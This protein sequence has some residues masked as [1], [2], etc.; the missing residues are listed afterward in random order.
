MKLF[1]LAIM[2]LVLIVTDSRVL[3]AQ[4]SIAQNSKMPKRLSDTSHINST[5][6]NSDS[7]RLSEIKQ[8]YALAKQYKDG[9]DVP[10]DYAKAFYYF[11][12]AAALGD[13]QSKYAEGYFYFKGLFVA[14]DYGIAAGLFQEGAYLGRDNSMYMLGLCFRNGYGLPQNE[15]SAQYWLKKSADAGYR[16]AILELQSKVPENGDAQAKQLVQRIHNAA[17]PEQVALNQF[18]ALQP[19]KPDSSI[20]AG[21]YEG[22]VIQYDWSG[23][24][25]VSTKKLHIFLEGQA[26]PNGALSGKWMEESGDSVT[27]NA[28]LKKDS[29]VFADTHYRRKDHYSPDSAILYNFENAALNLVRKGDSVFLAGNIY[30]FSPDRKEPSK[31]L[32]VALTR[33]TASTADSSV[34]K[35]QTP[36]STDSSNT[37]QA[38][39]LLNVYPNPFSSYVNVA[40][41]VNKASSVGIDLYNMAGQLVYQKA[42]QPLAPGRYTIRVEPPNQLPTQ[43]YLLRLV[44]T[45]GQEVAKVIKK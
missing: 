23:Q 45:G 42:A 3:V 27:I 8:Y 10:M 28:S 41:E 12:Q 15:D 32:F 20:I 11:S 6:I 16:Q 35:K 44:F 30:M 43:T 21:D 25:P 37:T 38:A 24:H 1:L 36:I 4:I 7:T 26:N 19:Q 22:Y 29:L 14:Q 13:E 18:I 9:D 33:T 34:I 17:V 40:F 2:P 31:P 5:V 39:R